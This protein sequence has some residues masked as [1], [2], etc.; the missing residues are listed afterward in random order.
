[1]LS[2]N[3]IKQIGKFYPDLKYITENGKNCLKGSLNFRAC[4]NNSNEEFIIDPS[5]K[6]IISDTYIDDKYDLEI[7]F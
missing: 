5:E 4:Y 6:M 2:E 3:V 7:E 1:M